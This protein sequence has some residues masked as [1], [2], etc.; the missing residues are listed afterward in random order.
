MQEFRFERV[1]MPDSVEALR[2]EVRVFI[3]GEVAAG[4]FTPKRN[5]WSSFDVAF[6][7]KCGERGFIGMMWPKQYGGGEKTA[8]HL[9]A[10]AGVGD[11]AGR[12]RILCRPCRLPGMGLAG[13]GPVNPAGQ[14]SGLT[15]IQSPCS[16]NANTA[17]AKTPATTA[18]RVPAMV[19]A[20]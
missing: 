16:Q 19:P 2:R 12:G 20:A 15:P 6:S 7:R 9:L 17:Q 18:P 13:Q 1:Q 10:A 4:S 8:G 5:A 11:G 14:P 3:A